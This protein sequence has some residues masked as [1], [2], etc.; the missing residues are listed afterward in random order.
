MIGLV[1]AATAAAIKSGEDQAVLRAKEKEMI[2]KMTPEARECF[3]KQREF[4]QKEREIRA[5]NNLASSTSRESNSLLYG[6][7]GFLF[8]TLL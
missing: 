8:G 5:L 7:V 4:Y 2:L 6:G 3:Y 1:G